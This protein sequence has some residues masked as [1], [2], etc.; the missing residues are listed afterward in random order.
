M[1]SKNKKVN[2]SGTYLGKY[3]KTVKLYSL[4]LE[5]ISRRSSVSTTTNRLF[6][7]GGGGNFLHIQLFQCDVM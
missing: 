3:W 5:Q 6:C 2:C 4:F 7:W 1:D